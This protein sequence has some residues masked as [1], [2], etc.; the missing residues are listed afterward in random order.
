[1]S[2]ESVTIAGKTCPHEFWERESSVATEGYCPL[3]MNEELKR[4][5]AVLRM[6]RTFLKNYQRTNA[7]WHN[8]M[9]TWEFV[10]KTLNP[11]I[12]DDE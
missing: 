5:R 12:G 3:C 1:M 6:T 4:L 7:N 11:V 2:E 8:D 10:T 9:P